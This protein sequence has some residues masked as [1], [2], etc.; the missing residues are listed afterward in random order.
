[1]K[2]GPGP[3]LL[4]VSGFLGSWVPQISSEGSEEPRNPGTRLHT[5]HSIGRGFGTVRWDEGSSDQEH[6]ST[7]RAVF[8]K[9]E[10]ATGAR[11]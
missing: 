7:S 6:D 5:S 9:I 8:F 2:K 3:T 10:Q 4:D 11:Q 1:M